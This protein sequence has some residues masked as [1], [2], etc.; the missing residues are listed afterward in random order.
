MET[1]VNQYG[2]VFMVTNDHWNHR[3]RLE[4]AQ[5]RNAVGFPNFVEVSLVLEAEEIID[6]VELLTK[7]RNFGRVANISLSHNK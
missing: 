6:E 3:D 7:D 2:Q 5:F 4:M 1:L